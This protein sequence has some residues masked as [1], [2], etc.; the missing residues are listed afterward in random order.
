VAAEERVEAVGVEEK[1]EWADSQQNL[2][3]QASV[4]AADAYICNSK[5]DCV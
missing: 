3:G 2:K 4:H 1:E 5:R